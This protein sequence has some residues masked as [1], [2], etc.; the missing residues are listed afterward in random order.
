ME[1]N[2]MTMEQKQ[3]NTF[4]CSEDHQMSE[5]ED[6]TSEEME[7]KEIEETDMFTFTLES[8]DQ[9]PEP[10]TPPNRS[11]H[12]GLIC[13]P[14]TDTEEPFTPE[15]RQQSNNIG[16][17]VPL[18]QQ[19]PFTPPN[20]RRG[21]IVGYEL[22][23]ST[24]QPRTP[25]NR[26][27]SN[28]IDLKVS[29]STQNPVTPPNRLPT[30]TLAPN[31]SITSTSSTFD[32]HTAVQM[33]RST[34]SQASYVPSSG[35]ESTLYPS[36]D[37]EDTEFD[38][39]DEDRVRDF[40]EGDGEYAN[41]SSTQGS[42]DRNQG[43]ENQYNQPPYPENRNEQPHHS[44]PAHHPHPLYLPARPPTSPPRLP[45]HTPLL[46]SLDKI[47]YNQKSA[48]DGH[49]LA[50]PLLVSPIRTNPQIQDQRDAEY[51]N[52]RMGYVLLAS[53]R[54]QA[55]VGV[56]NDLVF[57]LPPPISGGVLGDKARERGMGEVGNEVD[58][59]TGRGLREYF[60]KMGQRYGVK[61][62]RC[63]ELVFS[64]FAM[65]LKSGIGKGEMIAC[66]GEGCRI[67]IGE[68]ELPTH[69][70]TTPWLTFLLSRPLLPAQ[71]TPSSFPTPVPNSWIFF[72]LPAQYA[73]ASP[74]AT[75]Q[76]NP[77]TKHM[78]QEY[79]L[80]QNGIPIIEFSS[81]PSELV[82]GWSK[83]GDRYRET[84]RGSEF[85]RRGE[86]GAWLGVEM[87]GARGGEKEWWERFYRGVFEDVRVWERVRRVMSR[88]GLRVS[89]AWREVEDTGSEDIGFEDGNVG[90]G[91]FKEDGSGVRQLISRDDA[92]VWREKRGREVQ[93]PMRI[94]RR[95]VGGRF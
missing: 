87:E 16:C 53:S 51:I 2:S 36:P 49:L 66:F 8:P 20:R 27:R 74:I 25:A 71:S 48:L 30:T 77:Y 94:K 79:Q 42:E 92:G 81:K 58:K 32:F 68:V 33:Q 76:Q 18:P 26:P 91:I 45:A 38:G 46:R 41:G 54:L 55:V 37:Y 14:S 22:T 62:R 10:R 56:R 43:F 89:V 93:M 35:T 73:E 63:E 21:D 31:P 3:V 17:R 52:A 57:E 82:H 50:S 23:I 83:W 39:M 95:P 24:H 80:S 15:T 11:S 6:N 84:M 60:L 90:L 4:V 40:Q 61:R 64:D 44:Y 75:S 85:R 65:N 70:T 13:R 9:D 1:I 47:F 5:K 72:A 7:V 69:N 34:S 19:N 29:I 86:E 59:E 67:E 78:R 12:K 28:I 88:G